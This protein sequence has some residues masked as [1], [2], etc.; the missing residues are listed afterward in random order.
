MMSRKEENSLF[1]HMCGLVSVLCSVYLDHLHVLTPSQIDSEQ[2][3]LFVPSEAN[4][5]HSRHCSPH[6][7]TT[8]NLN[9]IINK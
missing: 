8:V 9:K 3:V 7:A 2:P 6:E 5:R 4:H 1:L